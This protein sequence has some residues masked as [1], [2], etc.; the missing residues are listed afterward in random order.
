MEK[1]GRAFASAAVLPPLP[2]KGGTCF[3]QQFIFEAECL[4]EKPRWT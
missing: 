2:P 3:T 1:D 4:I